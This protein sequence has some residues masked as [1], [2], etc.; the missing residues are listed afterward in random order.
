MD[1]RR[2]KWFITWKGGVELHLYEF[3]LAQSKPR[4]YIAVTKPTSLTEALTETQYEAPL[5]A[6][7]EL[8]LETGWLDN[9]GE[10]CPPVSHPLIASPLVEETPIIKMALQP[11]QPT[12]MQQ[13]PRAQTTPALTF[14]EERPAGPVQTTQLQMRALERR[15]ATQVNR[16]SATT[17]EAR[18]ALA[19]ISIQAKRGNTKAA[20]TMERPA[21]KTKVTP[22]SAR[23]PK[24]AKKGSTP[25]VT[26]ENP[27]GLLGADN[28]DD[29]PVCGYGCKHSGLVEL[30]QMMP[31]D[32]RFCLEKGNYFDSKC[33]IDCKT[34]IASVFKASKQKAVIYYCPVDYNVSNLQDENAAIAES[35]C[36]CILCIT[37]YFEREAKKTV[38]SGKTTRTS[39][40]GCGQ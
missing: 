24:K 36:A 4:N 21:K 10:N 23:T 7:E 33:C 19:T 16:N 20:G 35:P 34:S 31:Y 12:Q 26:T 32:T 25:K 39:R 27:V 5:D 1:V 28:N 38:A 40:R 18:R 3:Q 6:W 9:P 11:V 14:M 29:M 17:P 15:F 37:C 30:K 2:A 13:A 8:E 22:K